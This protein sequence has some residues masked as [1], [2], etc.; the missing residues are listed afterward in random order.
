M[1]SFA[2]AASIDAKAYMLVGAIWIAFYW[3][4]VMLIIKYRKRRSLL[5]TIMYW[6][7]RG[8]DEKEH[9]LFTADAAILS[10]ARVADEI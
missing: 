7:K 8:R 3:T 5:D 9:P 4:M 6:Q 2:Y 1:V 10:T